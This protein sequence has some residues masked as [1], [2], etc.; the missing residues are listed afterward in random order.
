MLLQAGSFLRPPGSG[1]GVEAFLLAFDE[2]AAY[3][4]PRITCGFRRRYRQVRLCP[5]VSC[6]G[7]R[8]GGAPGAAPNARRLYADLFGRAGPGGATTLS[9]CEVQQ[10]SAEIRRPMLSP[11]SRDRGFAGGSGKAADTTR[12]GKT[13]RLSHTRRDSTLPPASDA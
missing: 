13:V 8:A 6:C 7:N 3:D 4:R 1:R 10:R 11:R 5:T 9:V 12:A 2:S